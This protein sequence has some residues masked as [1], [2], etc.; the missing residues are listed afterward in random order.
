MNRTMHE[1]EPEEVMAYLD[2][3]LE[4]S[5]ASEVAAHIVGCAECAAVAADLRRVSLNF[6]QWQIEEAPASVAKTLEQAIAR[7]SAR[8]NAPRSKATIPCRGIF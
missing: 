3:E 4:A 8:I 6:V 2:G 7:P 5:R 1:I